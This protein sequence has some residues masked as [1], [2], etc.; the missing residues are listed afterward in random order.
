MSKKASIVSI[1]SQTAR[2][3]TTGVGG[4]GAQ[5]REEGEPLIISEMKYKK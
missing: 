4:G 5:R 3:R 1:G 2:E